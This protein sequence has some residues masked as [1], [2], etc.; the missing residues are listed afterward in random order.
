MI[1][2]GVDH[3]L[4]HPCGL[5]VLDTDLDAPVLFTRALAYARSLDADERAMALYV[6]ADSLCRQ[7]GVQ[8]LAVE[9]TYH[10]KNARTTIVLEHAAGLLRGVA[11]ARGARFVR[12][13]HEETDATAATLPRAWLDFSHIPTGQRVHA[14]DAVAIAWHGAG[15]A[16]RAAL[17]EKAGV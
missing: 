1:V 12:V 14:A 2:L 7:Y 6:T 5:A 10:G 9:Q 15:L 17:L 13:S 3:A 4:N 11:L 16:A 8:A